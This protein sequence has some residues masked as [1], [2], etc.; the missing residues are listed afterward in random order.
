MHTIPLAAEKYHLQKLAKVLNYQLSS[1]IL[2]PILLIAP[3]S[4]PI[5][6]IV[7]IIFT[8]FMLYHLYQSGK[9]KWIAGF[10]IAIILPAILVELFVKG[11]LFRGILNLMPLAA[12]YI[13]ALALKMFINERIEALKAREEYERIKSAKKLELDV[14]QNQFDQKQADLPDEKL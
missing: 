12:F 4:L 8:P 6:R 3:L 1:S 2:I 5:I 14:W 9:V 7:A 10:V 13:Y 11:P